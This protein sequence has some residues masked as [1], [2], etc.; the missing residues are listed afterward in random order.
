MADVTYVKSMTTTQGR[1]VSAWY[2]PG[3]LNPG[4][5]FACYVDKQRVEAGWHPGVTLERAEEIAQEMVAYRV[6]EI[7]EYGWSHGRQVIDD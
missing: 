5:H 2:Q 6:R 7:N 4:Y 3:K 1:E